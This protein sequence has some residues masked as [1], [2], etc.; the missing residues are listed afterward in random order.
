MIFHYRHK[1]IMKPIRE[2][3]KCPIYK[4]SMS[5]LQVLKYMNLSLVTG[6]ILPKSVILVTE[7]SITVFL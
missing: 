3:N 1:N 4:Q 7:E 6:Y 5:A 2:K